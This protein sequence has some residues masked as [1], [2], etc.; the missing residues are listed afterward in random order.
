MNSNSIAQSGIA[1]TYGSFSLSKTNVQ[2]QAPWQP[3]VAFYIIFQLDFSNTL[4]IL[5]VTHLIQF[6]FLV[7]KTSLF[8]R[9]LYEVSPPV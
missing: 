6:C 3:S 5:L 4:N 8:T 2:T 1:S 9:Y 7:F